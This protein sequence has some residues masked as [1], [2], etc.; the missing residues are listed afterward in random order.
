MSCLLALSQAFWGLVC[1]CVRNSGIWTFEIRLH[2]RS[3]GPLLR[4]IVKSSSRHTASIYLKYALE[5]NE[6][7][8]W[9][10]NPRQ[11]RIASNTSVL[12]LQAFT[13]ALLR[14]LN[15][16]RDF[17]QQKKECFVSEPGLLGLNGR[18]GKVARWSKQLALYLLWYAPQWNTCVAAQC[19]GILW[20][21]RRL[22]KFSPPVSPSRTPSSTRYGTSFVALAAF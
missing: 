4:R 20:S 14:Q 22:R 7:K 11:Q 17:G 13:S 12:E 19:L 1:Y 6:R 5:R 16:S 21:S 15:F 3:A 10:T 2:R 18:V 8:N 9:E